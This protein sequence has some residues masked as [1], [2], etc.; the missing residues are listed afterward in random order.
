M[1]VSPRAGLASMNGSPLTWS[2]V[3]GTHRRLGSAVEMDCF[4]FGCNPSSTVRVQYVYELACRRTDSPR[5][6]MRGYPYATSIRTATR[7]AVPAN[8]WRT[9]PE[10]GRWRGAWPRG[11]RGEQCVIRIDNDSCNDY[12]SEARFRSAETRPSRVGAIL[13]LMMA[14]LSRSCRLRFH[15]SCVVLGPKQGPGCRAHQAACVA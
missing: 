2:V 15:E 9:T 14:Q 6:L 11:R 10:A 8:R 7:T 3:R 13:V 4:A 12:T 1:T 5:L